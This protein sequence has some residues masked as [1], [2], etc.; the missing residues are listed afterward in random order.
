MSV[1]KSKPK[2]HQFLREA[3]GR[4]FPCLPSVQFSSVAQSCPTL[5]DTR[6]PIF[7]GLSPHSSNFKARNVRDSHFYIA[8]YQILCF[9]PLFFKFFFPSFWLCWVFIAAHWRSLVVASGG[10][11]PV[12]LCGLLAAVASAVA[13]QGLRAP[14]LQWLR[15]LGSAVV[16]RGLSCPVARGIFPARD[17]T[18]CPLP[19]QADS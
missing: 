5:C 16:V 15:H 8:I 13:E 18:L 3:Q 19:Q 2:C 4:L 11:S 10:C 9:L 14:G 1:T 6:P 17:G 7:L 12:E